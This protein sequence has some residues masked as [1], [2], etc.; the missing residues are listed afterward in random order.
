MKHQIT[1]NR[2]KKQSMGLITVRDP[3]TDQ[4]SDHIVV[5][6]ANQDDDGRKPYQELYGRYSGH[7]LL[8]RD[9]LSFGS[10]LEICLDAYFWITT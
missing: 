3:D 5:K 4:T 6:E 7:R 9:S 2:N 10:I 8:F 1:R